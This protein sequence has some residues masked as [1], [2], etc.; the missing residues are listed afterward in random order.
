[1]PRVMSR[2]LLDVTNRAIQ[3]A[4]AHGSKVVSLRPLDAVSAYSRILVHQSSARS[5]EPLNE[6]GDVENA[7]KPNYQV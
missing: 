3:V 6:F 7:G 1:M 4:G 5:L 2:L